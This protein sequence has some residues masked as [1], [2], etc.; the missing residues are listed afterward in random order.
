MIGLIWL[1]WLDGLLLVDLIWLD[2]M[3]WGLVD[4]MV[5][6]PFLS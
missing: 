5:D 4:K 2:D 3:N 6:F 1:I